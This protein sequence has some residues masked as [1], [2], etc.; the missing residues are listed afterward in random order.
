MMATLQWTCNNCHR[1]NPMNQFEC[2]CGRIA[3]GIVG[4]GCNMDIEWDTLST[5]S[6]I[7]VPSALC[8]IDDNNFMV[9]H[10]DYSSV[11]FSKYNIHKDEWKITGIPLNQTHNSGPFGFCYN[12]LQT[13]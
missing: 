13:I 7:H 10:G 5:H 12:L 1:R 11:R 9:G 2:K 3:T 8:K 6:S 4:W